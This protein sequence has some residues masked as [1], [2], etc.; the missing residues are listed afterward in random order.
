V[1]SSHRSATPLSDCFESW[2]ST[3]GGNDLARLCGAI[4][5][6]QFLYIGI[7]LKEQNFK[8]FVTFL[9]DKVSLASKNFIDTLKFQ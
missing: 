1:S 4:V 8:G 3:G 2:G 7:S 6:L 5:N 9:G